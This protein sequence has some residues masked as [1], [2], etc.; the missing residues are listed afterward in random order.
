MAGGWLVQWALHHY[1][2]CLLFV[3]CI[4]TCIRSQA[5]KTI[6][7]ISD[8]SKKQDSFELVITYLL[9]YIHDGTMII[10]MYV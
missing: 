9:L 2:T 8:Q 4:I 1:L 5:N 10:A 3:D 6:I 7:I